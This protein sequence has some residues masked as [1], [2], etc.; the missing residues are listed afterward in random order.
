[1]SKIDDLTKKLVDELEPVKKMKPPEVIALKW[2]L[3]G[4]SYVAILPLFLQFRYDISD[5]MNEPVFIIELIVAAIGSVLSCLTAAYFAAP[6]SHQKKNL[7]LLATI[8]FIALTVI[9]II[10]LIDQGSSNTMINTTTA[11][12]K[13]FADMFAFAAFP[14]LVMVFLAKKGASTNQSWSG[15]M[16]SLSAV[17]FSYIALRLIE[18]NDEAEHILIWH[19]APMLLMVI[20]G[21]NIG[22]KF[23]KW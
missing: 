21:M 3:S 17:N 16:I 14:I 15:A 7:K 20:I 9:L 5:K 23:L 18:P 12:Y 4:F 13:C 2:F 10:R 1:M 6:D 19:Y 11:T 8:P 22:R